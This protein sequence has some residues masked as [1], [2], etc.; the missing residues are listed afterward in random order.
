MNNVKLKFLS[1]LLIVFYLFSPINLW[2][3]G[4][5]TDAQLI[6]TG[7]AKQKDAWNSGDIK[8]FMTMYENSPATLY[9]TN[10]G[11]VQGYQA[12]QQRYLQKYA[13]KAKMGALSYNNLQIKLLS[14]QS[15]L[16]IGQWFLQRT[17]DNGG[18]TG[19]YFTLLFTKTDQGWKIAVDHT[20]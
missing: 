18:D 17:R 7:L 3:A 12:I 15:A 8:T 5:S 14:A 16:V 10:K 4:A 2:A 20:S 6:V 9:V 19:G 1:L 13:G 11:V